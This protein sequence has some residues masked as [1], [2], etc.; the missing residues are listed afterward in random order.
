MS[1]S[2]ECSPDYPYDV[3]VSDMFHTWEHHKVED[4]TNYRDKSFVS[5]FTGGHPSSFKSHF[6]SVFKIQD[7]LCLLFNKL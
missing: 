7:A 2:R 5:K 3:D 1:D 6:P 4:I